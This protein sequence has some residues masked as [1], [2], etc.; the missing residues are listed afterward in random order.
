[1]RIKSTSFG[2]PTNTLTTKK[3]RKI[4]LR[5]LNVVLPDK[6]AAQLAAVTGGLH[7]Q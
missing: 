1:M 6:K 3:E 2:V 7:E 5:W 4:S